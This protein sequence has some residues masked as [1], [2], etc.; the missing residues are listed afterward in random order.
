MFPYMVIVRW[1]FYIRR[2]FRI[3]G[4]RHVMN[5]FLVIFCFFLNIAS[6]F[7]FKCSKNVSTIRW[8]LWRYKWYPAFIQF[9]RKTVFLFSQTHIKNISKENCFAHHDDNM[10]FQPSPRYH[11]ILIR[12]IKELLQSLDA[13]CF[14]YQQVERLYA[15][16]KYRFSS[17]N[18]VSSALLFKIVQSTVCFN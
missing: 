2:L 6:F 1:F 9:F 16:L 14:N 17:K 12:D 18:V 11:I 8:R 3:F 15:L 13:F 7:R 10:L 5:R 4:Y